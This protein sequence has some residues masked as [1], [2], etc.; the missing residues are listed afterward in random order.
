MMIQLSSLPGPAER[1]A[2]AAESLY[3]G[4][5]VIALTGRY[6]DPAECQDA[7]LGD[8]RLQ[9][10]AR[11]AISADDAESPANQLGALLGIDIELLLVGGD[12]E[13]PSGYVFHVDGL[14]ALDPAILAAWYDFARR[15]A[16]IAQ[17]A[18]SEART[19]PPLLLCLAGRAEVNL[20]DE[21]VLLEHVQLYRSLDALDIRCLVRSRAGGAF[22]AK[23]VWREHVLPALVGADPELVDRC[24]DACVDGVDALERVFAEVARARGWTTSV[25]RPLARPQ[26]RLGAELAGTHFLRRG[27]AWTPHLACALTARGKTEIEQRLWRGQASF[28]LPYL[29]QVRLALCERL[30]ARLGPGWA[31]RF[32][33][34]FSEDECELVNKSHLHC[35][36][37]HLRAVISAA[38]RFRERE[39]LLPIAAQAR[40]MRNEL[41]HYRPVLFRD[42]HV[43]LQRVTRAELPC[44]LSVV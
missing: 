42:L 11:M 17:S 1:C 25:M 15:Y 40:Q 6:L 28:L 26:E 22:D 39:P 27:G 33:Q 31:L 32:A 19:L 14:D 44:A 36:F 34:P 24:W 23:T 13:L 43:L 29:D 35:Q 18:R 7:I 37:G 8:R 3:A 10:W 2:R 16:A 9:H 5:S 30:E 20:P 38:P 4:R 41:A 21:N 12:V